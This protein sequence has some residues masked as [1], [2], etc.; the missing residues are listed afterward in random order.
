MAIIVLAGL[1]L[2][3]SAGFAEVTRVVSAIGR[4]V[5]FGQDTPSAAVVVY[6]QPPGAVFHAW[7]GTRTGCQSTGGDEHGAPGAPSVSGVTVVVTGS[8]QGPRGTKPAVGFSISRLAVLP[9]G[10]IVVTLSSPTR[11]RFVAGAA[12]SAVDGR[13]GR[14]RLHLHGA[15]GSGSATLAKRG[16][17]K[18]GI[19]PT[20]SAGRALATGA[21]LTVSIGVTLTPVAGTAQTRTVTLTVS[22]R[23]GGETTKA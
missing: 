6:C 19:A 22:E 21:R 2:G 10:V 3:V 7:G 1:G 13:P 8:G 17:V 23:R 14:K 18:L 16:S 20:R 9:H 15:Y 5:S 11:G 12:F 4:S